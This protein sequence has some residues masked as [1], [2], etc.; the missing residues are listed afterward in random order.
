M[1]FVLLTHSFILRRRAAGYLPS[2]FNKKDVIKS[3]KKI[4][5]EV[6]EDEDN[7]QFQDQTWPIYSNS[8]AVENEDDFLKSW[9]DILNNTS[10][11]QK[12]W[13]KKAIHRIKCK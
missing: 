11:S 10:D 2:L 13:N 8:L 12:K 3:L 6:R 1:T 9:D 5:S 4:I 7:T